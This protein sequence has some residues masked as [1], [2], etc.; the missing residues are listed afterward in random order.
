MSTVSYNTPNRTEP[1]V[2]SASSAYDELVGGSPVMQEVFR[3]IERVAPTNASVLITGESGTG[4]Q[5]A[6]HAIHNLS[7]RRTRPFVSVNCGAVRDASDVFE[8][9][10]GGT[11]V[12][13]EITEMPMDMQVRL[14]SANES[15]GDIR[16]IAT[17]N[18]CPFT[19]VKNGQLREDLLYRLAAFPI[20][21]PPLRNRGEDVELLANHF[22]EELNEHAGSQKRLSTMSR[23]KLRQ[24]GWPGN[25]RELKDC[26]E[27]AFILTDSVLEVAPLMQSGGSRG[28]SGLGD[29]LEIRVGSRIHDMERSLIEA[30]LDYFK[31]N[32]R[33]A[34]DA[35]GCSLKTLYNKLNGYSQRQEL[36]NS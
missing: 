21:L 27:R 23:M 7:T 13:D 3:L 29:R 34:A 4:K 12:L 18:R 28:D 32:K 16:L 9:A 36:A 5:L 15:E 8:R 11:L 19:A 2:M 20:T 35:L 17:S 33:R 26:I 30:T 25:V 10:Q 31:G 6:A 24:H 22:L 14:L 1:S